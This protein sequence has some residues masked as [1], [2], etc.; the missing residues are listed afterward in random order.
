MTRNRLLALSLAG[1]AGCGLLLGGFAASG[2]DAKTPT[3]KPPTKTTTHHPQPGMMVLV[4]LKVSF[5]RA[6]AARN[7]ALTRGRTLYFVPA[8]PS[9][10]ADWTVSS[11]KAGVVAITPANAAGKMSPDP[12]IQGV[13]DGHTVITVKSKKGSQAYT[14]T[15]TVSTPEIAPGHIINY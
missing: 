12:A 4:P 11:S 6:G 2:S 15:V 5:Q 8:N 13:G 1:V 7:Y 14:F 3:V 10:V 9:T